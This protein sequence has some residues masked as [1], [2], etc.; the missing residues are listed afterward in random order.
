MKGHNKRIEYKEKDLF[1]FRFKIFLRWC[2]EQIDKSI[3]KRFSRELEVNS[4]GVYKDSKSI[5]YVAKI[6]Y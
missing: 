1:D 6:G 4:I 5:D 3:Q 2:D